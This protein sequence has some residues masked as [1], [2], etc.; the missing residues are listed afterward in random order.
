MPPSPPTPDANDLI[1]VSDTGKIFLIKMKAVSGGNVPSSISELPSGV[2]AVPRLLRDQNAT[3]AILPDEPDGGGATCTL[4]NML[5]IKP[6]L[7]PKLTQSQQA[8]IDAQRAVEAGHQVAIV[9]K[10]G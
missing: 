5:S 1:L 3:L 6:A 2:A 8:I 4:L 7:R 10:S 9:S